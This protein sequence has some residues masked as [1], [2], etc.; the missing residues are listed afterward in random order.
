MGKWPLYRANQKLVVRLRWLFLA[1]FAKILGLGEGRLQNVS[2]MLKQTAKYILHVEACLAFFFNFSCVVILA[3]V[4]VNNKFR[5]RTAFS[6]KNFSFSKEALSLRKS[7]YCF[8]YP[9]ASG[10]TNSQKRQLHIGNTKGSF[11][12]F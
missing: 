5:N 6:V 3:C 9:K 1:S 10:F 11:F 7:Q 2:S 4:S 12:F 8:F